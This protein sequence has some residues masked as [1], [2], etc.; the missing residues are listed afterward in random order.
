MA[1][2]QQPVEESGE[3]GE[4]VFDGGFVGRG[5]VEGC[6]TGGWIFRDQCIDRRIGRL[7]YAQYVGN[8]AH[9]FQAAGH[10]VSDIIAAMQRCGLFVV[11]ED[12]DLE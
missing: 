8:P 1:P 3:C 10:G 11:A 4:N 5:D 12:A 6:A 9:C 7:G 2:P